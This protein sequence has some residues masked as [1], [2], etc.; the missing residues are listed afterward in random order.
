ML[1]TENMVLDDPES[2]RDSKKVVIFLNVLIKMELRTFPFIQFLAPS[3]M[4]SLH[5]WDHLIQKQ[6]LFTNF[7][8]KSF[9]LWF[10]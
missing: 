10:E 9:S 4:H 3:S 1:K 7:I 5:L 8:E 2:I 6:R